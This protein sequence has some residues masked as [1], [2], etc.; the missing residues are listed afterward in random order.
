[1]THPVLKNSRIMIRDAYVVIFHAL[2]DKVRSLLEEM[3][4]SNIVVTGN[5]GIGKSCFYLYC[6]F[7]LV[8]GHQE[9]V[10][11]LSSIVLNNDAQ[12]HK[13]DPSK[14]EFLELNERE[15]LLLKQ[16]NNVVRLIEGKSSLL[17]GWNGV[18]ILFASPGVERLN[19]YLKVNSS[20]HIMPV[21]SF[22]ELQDY[23]SLFD[24]ERKLSDNDLISRYEKFG[25]IPR[26]IF[27]NEQELN[28]LELQQAIL[29]FKP[30]EIISYVKLNNA[31]RQTNYS[32]RILQMVPTSKN[33][34]G[35][36][37]L[38]FLTNYIAEQTFQ[39]VTEAC[40]NKISEFAIA[41]AND[42]SGMTSS[43]FGKI[44][45]AMCHN[46]FKLRKQGILQLRQLSSSLSILV[47]IVPE[48][49]Q[50]I[51]FSTLDE[52]CTIPQA[53]TYYQPLSSTFGALDAFILD[54]INKICY[55]LQITINLNHGIKA[56]P[57]NS[58]LL[59]LEAVGIPL[60]RFY[61]VFVVPCNLASQYKSQT[62][63]TVKGQ[64]HQRVGALKKLQQFVTGLDVFI[65]K[66]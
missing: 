60:T 62:I 6:I 34:G 32:H 47:L 37:Y 61:F 19:E 5:P 22:E 10:L 57:L 20:R 26:F 53:L 8:H 21:W 29:S 56:A 36:Y 7:Q 30:L 24:G 46:W 43:T 25:G 38:E 3:S 13:Y 16:E 63:Q 50:I 31:V 35:G 59:W 28:D 9:K 14:K 2:M 54:G 17:T 15:V 48:D 1:M 65:V 4:I 49:M 58:F 44:Y 66:A 12:Y 33:L 52:I 23:N 51:K 55:G 41:H 45:E 42:D 39:E 18:S 64:I 27:S 40:M 11:A